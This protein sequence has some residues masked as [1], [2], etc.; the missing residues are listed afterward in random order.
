MGGWC[1]TYWGSHGCDLPSGHD[2]YH[3]CT[4][5]GTPEGFPCT[6]SDGVRV[7]YWDTA[8]DRWDGWAVRYEGDVWTE[9]DA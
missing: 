2:G 1:R 3:R 6:E 9:E 8:A 4:G 7:R 5:D